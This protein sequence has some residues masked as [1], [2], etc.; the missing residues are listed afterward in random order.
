MRNFHADLD[1]NF[2]ET[3]ALFDGE[4]YS[5][6]TGLP[7]KAPISEVFGCKE[8]WNIPKTSRYCAEILRKT[9][10]DC[11]RSLP[12]EIWVVVGVHFD[13]CLFAHGKET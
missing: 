7:I 5:Q 4:R 13:Q 12:H 1:L 2:P 3:Q 11:F 6:R 9:F 8:D 10:A